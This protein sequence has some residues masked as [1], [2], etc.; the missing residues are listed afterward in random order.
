MSLR[1]YFQTCLDLPSVSGAFCLTLDGELI[2]SFM[3]SPYT[4][5]MFD[6]LGPRITSLLG[7]V[8]MSY[9]QTNE[10]LVR[11]ETHAL[12]LRQ[13]EQCII[14]IF[15]AGN[16]HVAGLRVS[17]NL[18]IKQA[19]QAITEKASTLHSQDRFAEDTT[20][21]SDGKEEEEEDII[22][23]PPKKRE[24]PPAP[25]KTKMGFF[26]RKKEKKSDSNDI[27]S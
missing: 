19:Q 11:F 21:Q 14:G 1:K 12:F 17:V 16:P 15:A 26:G 13:N 9:A 6:E 3:P 8:D 22:I 18:L 23:A 27:W 2:E 4:E 7:A 25:A 5:S 10:L 20:A 24:E